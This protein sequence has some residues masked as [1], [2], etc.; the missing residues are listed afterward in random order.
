[1]TQN[2]PNLMSDTEPQIQEMYSIKYACAKV[3]IYILMYKM[4]YGITKDSRKKLGLF[5]HFKV[6]SVLIK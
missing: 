3:Y 5:C 1:M 2:F 4:N 6:L